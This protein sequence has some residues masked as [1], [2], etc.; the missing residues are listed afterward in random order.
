MCTLGCIVPTQRERDF[1]GVVSS[2]NAPAAGNDRA[3]EL[4]RGRYLP[5]R[6]PVR[7]PGPVR[8]HT[9]ILLVRSARRVLRKCGVDRIGERPDP[10]GSAGTGAGRSLRRGL[11]PD[12]GDEKSNQETVNTYLRVSV[13]GTHIEKRAQMPEDVAWAKKRDVTVRKNRCENA[14]LSVQRRGQKCLQHSAS[15]GL[16]GRSRQHSPPAHAP[17]KLGRVADI[18]RT[19]SK[20]PV[21][22]HCRQRLG[23]PKAA[24]TSDKR[25]SRS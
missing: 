7:C 24:L 13:R 17:A 23:E 22:Y 8:P 19:P 21:K 2:G 1:H 12:C 4:R 18:L 25:V 14:G 10:C 3:R 20:D 11:R 16:P 5:S 9:G 15:D 6:L